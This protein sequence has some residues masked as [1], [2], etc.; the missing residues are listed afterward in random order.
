MIK[1]TLHLCCLLSCRDIKGGNILIMPSGV[2]KLIDFGCAKRLYMVCLML[3]TTY[4]YSFVWI[5][6]VHIFVGQFYVE[7]LML[8]LRN[9][10]LILSRL[11]IQTTGWN[12]ARN[13]RRFHSSELHLLDFSFD[14][15][16]S[17]SPLGTTATSAICRRDAGTLH[18]LHW[19][20]LFHDQLPN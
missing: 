4:K 19:E 2:L 3:R 16:K 18:L 8:L 14:A 6:S 7:V 10:L 12:T 17:M 9:I 1:H 20:K 11:T 13:S 15:N 5:S